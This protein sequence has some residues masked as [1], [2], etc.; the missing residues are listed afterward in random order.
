[1][2]K[3]KF[4]EIEQQPKEKNSIPKIMGF[5]LLPIG[6]IA[7]GS[8][9]LLS[10]N[11]FTFPSFSSEKATLKVSGRIEGDETNLGSKVGGKINLVS[12]D[13]GDIVQKGQILVTLDDQ[14]IQAQLKGAIA[15][16]LSL[17]QQE[18]EAKLQINSLENQIQELSL[19]F[20]Q[21]E[22][23][24]KGQI[25]QAEASLASSVAQLNEAIAKLESAQ[26][27]LKLAQKE[28]DRLAMLIT[29]GAISQQKFD[30]SQ[31][32]LETNQATV[33][34]NESSIKSFEK[35][36]KAAEAQV[37]QAKTSNFNSE[38]VNTKIQRLDIQLEQAKLQLTQAQAEVANAQAMEQ[39]IKS[40]I[41]YLKIPSTINGVI[42]SRL[43]EPGEVITNGQTVLIILDPQSVYL[44]G[45]IAGGD[46][47]KVK[48]GQKAKVFLD[49]DSKM[50]LEATVTNIDS[51]A[52]FT[53]E[54]TYFKEDRVKQVFGVKLKIDNPQGN[55]KPGMPADAEIINN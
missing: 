18:L 16:T 39:E 19:N 33:K 12:V 4:L 49:S 53:P 5:L 35:L 44:K 8:F 14:E 29:E 51:Q 34:A 28:R 45:Y 7:V 15:K 47:G 3:D 17:K 21:A 43:I 6:I 52:N 36:V 25:L 11:Y 50:P 37:L 9:F 55:A 2:T 23:S 48:I 1:M 27:N 46:I 42:T 32:K 20:Q 54:N 31:I 10:N 13:E 40:K 24:A 30:E 38:I 26:A 41:D 22:G